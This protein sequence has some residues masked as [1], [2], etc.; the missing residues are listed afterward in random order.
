MSSS[1]SDRQATLNSWM[2]KVDPKYRANTHW[3]LTHNI[4]PNLYWKWD[5]VPERPPGDFVGNPRAIQREGFCAPGCD[6]PLCR[7]GHGP[8]CGCDMCARVRSGCQCSC[9]GCPD[10]GMSMCNCQCSTVRRVAA[11]CGHHSG[12]M[13]M[14]VLILIAAG[15]LIVSNLEEK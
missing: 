9:K 4:D 10:C 2:E 8:R 11:K 13:L 12:K 15:V 7:A 3:L 14:I 5:N 1:P 6:C